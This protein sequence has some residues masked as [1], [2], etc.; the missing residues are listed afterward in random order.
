MIMNDQTETASDPKAAAPLAKP[1]H[2]CFILGRPR[3]GT[4]VFKDML[5]T[6]PRI[7]SAGEIFNESN[8]QSY[9]HFLQEQIAG[10][11]AAVLPSH[12]IANFL[13]YLDWCQQRAVERKKH[14]RIVV[15]DV[16]YDQSH[17]IY[18]PWWRVG[19]LPKIFFLIRER[20]WKVID[21]HRSDIVGLVVSNQVAIQTKIY[22]STALEPGAKQSARV[23]INP[24][25]LK[26]ELTTT[27]SAYQTIHRHFANYK[28]Y[29][30]LTYEEMFDGGAG[31]VFAGD[32]IN[33]LCAFLG[34]EDKFNRQPKLEKLL[35]DDVYTHIENAWEIR[36]LVDSLR[37]PKPD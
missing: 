31:G 13:N 14:A 17:L 7:Y 19:S 3:S 18:D 34:V 28:N 27:A 16:K 26:R 10:D 22:H 8:S 1:M 29:L 4:T 11:P 33:R 35:G 30:M 15:A 24:N 36:E 25:L 37:K 23:Y 9:F 2:F 32:V 6:H 20:G 5:K 12:S 21:I